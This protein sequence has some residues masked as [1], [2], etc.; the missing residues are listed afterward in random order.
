MPK[1]EPDRLSQF[2]PG[3][4]RYCEAP[5]EIGPRLLRIQFIAEN[6]FYVRNRRLLSR[7]VVLLND[8][9][10]QGDRQA[11]FPVQAKPIVRRSQNASEA[12]DH[13][14][15]DSYLLTAKHNHLPSYIPKRPKS[16]KLAPAPPPDR[17]FRFTSPFPFGVIETSLRPGTEYNQIDG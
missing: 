3:R 14:S 15:P 6:H 4:H 17:H 9:A 1:S 7:I 13:Q 5:R 2:R 16:R 10:F 12:C 11:I 8:C